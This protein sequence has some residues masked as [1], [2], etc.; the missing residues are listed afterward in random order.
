MIGLGSQTVPWLEPTPVR[1]DDIDR[2]HTQTR[3]PASVCELL[4]RRGVA[5]PHE[6]RA[7]LRPDLSGLHDP[8]LL[9]DLPAAADRIMDAVASGETVLVHGDYD[10]DGLTATA[11]LTRGL[12]ELGGHAS[13][14]VPHRLRDGYDLSS[15]GLRHAG[16][17]G[18][19][20]LVTV[21]CGVTANE[22]VQE[23]NARGL[24]VI[25]TDHH[26]PGAQLPAALAVVNPQRAD[27]RYPNRSLAGVGV[28]F[29]L[30]TELFRRAERSETDLNQH[31]DLVALGSIADQVPLLG[32]NRAMAAAGLKV[33]AA[34][35]KP[36]VR[37]LLERV[38]HDA[39]GPVRATDISFRLAPR[40]NSAGR[41]GSADPALHLLLE[42]R[43]A[44]AHRLAAFLEARNAERRAEVDR[45][46]DD[47]ESGLDRIAL[48]DTEPMTM[49]SGDG[50]PFG[51]VGIVA[52]RL[53]DRFHRPSV[54][55]AIEGDIGRGSARS[56]PGVNLHA[57]L[58]ECA[59]LLERFGGHSMAAGLT[60]RPD[61]IPE[62]Q[63]RLGALIREQASA[64][65]ESSGLATD[66]VLPLADVHRELYE[67]LARLEPFGNSNPA[68]VLVSRTVSFAKVERVGPALS[69]LRAELLGPDG[70]RLPAIGFG[71]GARAAEAGE[72][73][74][75][76]VAYELQI[77]RY[78]GRSRLQARLR[79]FRP[80]PV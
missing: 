49:I 21:D 17:I 45:V 47:V 37:A 55:I 29:K 25:V 60:V 5:S 1:A 19:S 41:L 30:L 20:L 58:R 43:P 35:A 59:D 73:T 48:P 56:V 53:V 31:L 34:S 72:L 7:F 33:V 13:G 79:D 9:P 76:D 75:A 70:G 6:V 77:H 23:A 62:L 36:G 27:N 42:D 64:A 10:A 44:E 57:A 8:A 69:H 14:F 24:D 15:S 12:T 63:D 68:P 71:M 2:L 74:S 4:I 65:S 3:L 66:L 18:A 50:W 39:S 61:R 38:G 22:A 52:S 46:Y 51:V 32:E 26:R 40:L 11:L 67:W 16:E 54:V 28:A 80:H 78:R